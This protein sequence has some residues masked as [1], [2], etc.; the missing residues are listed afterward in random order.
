M[1]GAMLPAI[2]VIAL[3]IAAAA[4]PAAGQSST[5]E[6]TKIDVSK[7]GPQ[8]GE[9][10]PDFSLPDQNGKTQTLTSIMGPKGAVIVFVRSADWC[11]YCKT[12]L[13]DLQGRVKELAA[14]G[15]GLA[16]ISYDPPGIHARFSQQRGI[17]YPLLADVGSVVIRKY[18]VVNP[19]GE[20]AF[21]P[22]KD[23]PAVKALVQRLVTG[24][25]PGPRHV[26]MALPGTLIVDRQGRVTSRFFEDYYVERAT[27]ANVM[28]RLGASP[29]PVAATRI[30]TPHLDI[31]AYPSDAAVAPG[32]R[33]SLVLDVAPKP[34]IHV[35][36]PGAKDY[37][38]IGVSVTPQPFV[39]VGPPVHPASEIYHF[40]PLDERVPVYQKPFRLVL[41]VVL[42]GH[43]EAQAARRDQESLTLAGTLDYQACDD[44]ICFNPVSLPLSWTVGLR[45]LVR[46]PTTAPQTR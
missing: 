17:T 37:R 27:M 11:P 24:G 7:L 33:F 42:E 19:V 22:A 43:P 29:S 40:K 6:S 21:G 23:D 30:A 46:E 39:R 5:A 20:M 10:V 9:R 34:G 25:A 36:A 1:A 45:S 38:V 2:F 15:L 12:Q 3:L 16:A 18:G 4:V 28:L 35:Y 14:Q 8:V 44:R 41:D 26:G 31:T 32:N 13:V